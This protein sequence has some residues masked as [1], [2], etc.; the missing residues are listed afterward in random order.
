MI[1][2]ISNIQSHLVLALSMSVENYEEFLVAFMTLNYKYY[3][4]NTSLKMN[5]CFNCKKD[6]TTKAV[7]S[8]TYRG[9]VIPDLLRGMDGDDLAILDFVIGLGAKSDVESAL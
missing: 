3:V 9:G 8:I 6:V 1:Y 7:N 4:F 2:Y 5:Y